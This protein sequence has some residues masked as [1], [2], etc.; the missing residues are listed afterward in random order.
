MLASFV[1]LNQPLQSF[2][3]KMSVV[4]PLLFLEERRGPMGR[5]ELGPA[6]HSCTSLCVRNN[7][8]LTHK[9][10]PS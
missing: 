4:S 7:G 6:Q 3:R 1:Q 9:Q 8:N 10:L 5:T 2:Q